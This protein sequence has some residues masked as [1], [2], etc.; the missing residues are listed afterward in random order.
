[1][2]KYRIVMPALKKVPQRVRFES[3]GKVMFVIR[4]MSM[5]VVN[6]G[7][8]ANNLKLVCIFLKTKIQFVYPMCKIK[9]FVF[10]FTQQI[11]TEE[12]I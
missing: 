8:V 6:T 12:C 5:H 2:Q 1:M 9:F 4:W 7:N 3:H 11:Q 10:H